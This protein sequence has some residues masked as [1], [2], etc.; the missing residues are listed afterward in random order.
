ML[1]TLLPCLVLTAALAAERPPAAL[2]GVDVY[3]SAHLDPV[4]AETRYGAQLKEYVLLRNAKE[5]ASAAKAE[6]IRRAVEADVRKLPGVAFAT[7]RITE[8]F[9]SVDHAMY[10]MFDIVDEEDRHRM[11]FAPAPAGRTSDPLGLLATWKEYSELGWALAR[12][13]LMPVDRPEC[14]GFFSLWGGATPELAALQQKLV[15]GVPGKLKE[16][17]EVLVHEADGGKRS[18]ALY[19]LS[20]AKDGGQLVE[21][22]LRALKDPDGKVRVAA[23]EILSDVALYHRGLRIDLERVLAALD[24]PRGE[25][26]SK[27]IGL[28]VPMSD[29]KAQRP[30]LLAAAPRL[31]ALLKL[32]QPESSDLAYVVLSQLSLKD[33]N[34]RDLDA[35]E[36]WAAAAAS[37][38]DE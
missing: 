3:R 4:Q 28:L 23:L 33:F 9:T 24:D 34:R 20:Y 15:D 36:Q 38:K 10:A 8:Y 16:L 31:V 30:R 14:P 26:R 18:A 22:C 13:G 21:D 12:Q 7:L 32:R 37:G 6:E 1:K 35:W 17:R 27:V 11:A 5:P 19:A 29:D 25:V 2:R